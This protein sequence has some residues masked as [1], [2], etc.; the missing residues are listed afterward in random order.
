MMNCTQKQSAG[1]P[2]NK[3]LHYTQKAKHKDKITLYIDDNWYIC[4][5]NSK[6]TTPSIKLE[7]FLKNNIKKFFN[8][9][10]ASIEYTASIFLV[11]YAISLVLFAK[12]SIKMTTNRVKVGNTLKKP[13]R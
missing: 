3:H 8:S 1:F 7:N 11:A 2:T 9:K 6:G 13:L 10:S 5:P 12:F 4:V